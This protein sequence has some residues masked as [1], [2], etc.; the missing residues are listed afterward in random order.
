MSCYVYVQPVASDGPLIKAFITVSAHQGHM[1]CIMASNGESFI[2][3]KWTKDLVGG[4]K[5]QLPPAGPDGKHEL[6]LGLRRKQT[7]MG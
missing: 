4:F 5:I 2:D 3:G 6:L 1:D 7:A